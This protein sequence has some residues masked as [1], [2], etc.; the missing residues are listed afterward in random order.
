MFTMF[1]VARCVDN[2]QRMVSAF[3]PLPEEDAEG[4]FCLSYVIGQETCAVPGTVGVIGF[5]TWDAALD[6]LTSEGLAR[7]DED[8]ECGAILRCETEHEPQLVDYLIS[9]I[10]VSWIECWTC[11]AEAPKYTRFAPVEGTVVVPAL[12]P[13][14]VVWSLRL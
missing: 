7:L 1:K 5:V 4:A 9:L 8:G 13:V 11:P 10:S 3:P 6:F 14:E 2:R 12:T